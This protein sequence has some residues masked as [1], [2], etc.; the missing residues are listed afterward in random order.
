LAP[1]KSAVKSSLKLKISKDDTDRVKSSFVMVI[2]TAP[3]TGGR[4]SIMARRVPV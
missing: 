2:Q 3:A 1:N 4:L